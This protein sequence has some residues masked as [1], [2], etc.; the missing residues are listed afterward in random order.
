[1]WPSEDFSGWD[2]TVSE[3]EEELSGIKEPKLD[4]TER[5][6]RSPIYSTRR[7]NDPTKPH[8][9][10]QLALVPCQDCCEDDD[11]DEA[12]TSLL[13]AGRGFSE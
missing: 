9:F 6:P 4:G 3:E 10:C 13:V 5:G 11:E 7:W 1:V 12:K 2:G 8:F